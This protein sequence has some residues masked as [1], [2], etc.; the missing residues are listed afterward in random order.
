MNTIAS[1]NEG[2]RNE[3][4][5]V[6]VQRC[7]DDNQRDI[8]VGCNGVEV[9]TGLV[10]NERNYFAQ[11]YALECLK[12]CAPTAVGELEKQLR[13]ASEQEL[14]SVV[15]GLKADSDEEKLAAVVRCPC[16]AIPDNCE[17]LQRVGVIP[18]LVKLVRNGNDSMKLWAAEALRYLAAGSEKC[19]PAIAMNGGVESLV[20]LVTSGTA[21]QTLV[22]VLALGNLAR[23]KV[24]S[25]AVVRKGG[26][27]P[28]IELL[29]S[30]TDS[31]KH[32]AVNTLGAIGSTNSADIIRHNGTAAT[33]LLNKLAMTLGNRDGIVRQGAIPPLVALLQNGNVEQQASALGAL[34]SLAATGSHAVE[35]IDKGASRPLLA[36]LQ[37]RAEDQKS[38]ALNLLLALSTNHEK[39][40]EIVREGA[41]PP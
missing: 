23:S 40:S 17:K 31:Q 7:V 16:M 15:N 12:W 22:A 41:I 36:I 30:G 10:R 24:V 33:S 14:T 11:L 8:V 37:T 28:L 13:G 26:I 2:E 35:I 38:M 5:L 9:L 25:E 39:S 4:L 21:Q 29:Q 6:L 27:S 19:R 1:G 32:A 18:L 20:T 3:A 34:T